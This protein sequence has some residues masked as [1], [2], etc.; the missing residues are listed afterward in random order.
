MVTGQKYFHQSKSKH[1]AFSNRLNIAIVVYIAALWWSPEWDSTKPINHPFKQNKNTNSMYMRS[2]S[3]PV[4]SLLKTRAGHPV[5][6][7]A[8]ALSIVP[9]GNCTCLHLCIDFITEREFAE[10]VTNQFLVKVVHFWIAVYLGSLWLSWITLSYLV[11]T[12]LLSYTVASSD[13]HSW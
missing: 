4:S 3:L 2:M 13:V 1:P 12:F 8:C 6:F 9:L 11:I 10:V 5:L 7:V